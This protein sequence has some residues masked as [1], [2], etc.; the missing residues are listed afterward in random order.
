MFR[1]MIIE[2]LV[3]RA[4]DGSALGL[5]ALK[6]LALAGSKPGRIRI[7]FGDPIV[8]LDMKRGKFSEE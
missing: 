8:K 7:S 5:V 4:G 1:D 6:Y 2:K 3:E